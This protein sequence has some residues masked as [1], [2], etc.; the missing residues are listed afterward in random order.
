ME[1]E[2]KDPQEKK[3]EELMEKEP[4]NTQEKKDEELIEKIFPRENNVE[5]PPRKRQKLEDTFCEQCF[6][7]NNEK[8]HPKECDNNSIELVHEI[9]NHK[10]KYIESLYDTIISEN[11]P[12][13][14]RW[15]IL[16]KIL[17]PF[18]IEMAYFDKLLFMEDSTHFIKQH[19]KIGDYLRLKIDYKESKNFDLMYNFG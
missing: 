13:L 1:K 7:V 15:K 8:D 14:H 9:V 3:D 12:L 6:E 17:S 16:R 19:G 11:T 2:P 10:T 4:K 5:E 18:R